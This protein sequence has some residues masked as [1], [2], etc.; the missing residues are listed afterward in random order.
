MC[1]L[2]TQLP[3]SPM[4]VSR[5][6]RLQIGHA[7]LY[8][9]QLDVSELH[10]GPLHRYECTP[11]WLLSASDSFCI[12]FYTLF[13]TV[14]SWWYCWCL[15]LQLR[16]GLRGVCIV[17]WSLLGANSRKC[18]SFCLIPIHLYHAVLLAQPEFATIAVKRK[19][20]RKRLWKCKG[21]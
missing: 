2:C 11:I 3:L 20:T 6:R 12:L 21:L 14:H 9:H 17:I 7:T 18:L 13:L 5:Y 1:E 16:G 19:M 10:D 4:E 15:H 8:I